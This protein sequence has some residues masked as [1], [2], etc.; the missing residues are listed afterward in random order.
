MRIAVLTSSRADYGIY[1][2]LL[3]GLSNDSFFQLRIIAFGTH[4]SPFH[5]YT[6]NQINNDGFN[7]YEKLETLILGDTEEAISNAIG[8]TITKFSSL[9]KKLKGEVELVFALGDR[10][11]MFAAVAASIPFNIKIAHLHGGETTSGAIDDKFRHSISLMSNI[12]FTSTSMYADKV[13]EIVG[14]KNKIFHVGSLSLDN[15]F[16]LKLLTKK[17]VQNNFNIDLSAPTILC[18]IHPETVSTDLN[19]SFANI[20]AEVFELVSDRYQVLITMPN[21]DTMGNV[22]RQRFQKLRDANSQ[23]ICVENLGTLGYFSCMK[24]SSFLLGNTSSGI[25]EAP[26]LQK[27]VIN[28]GNRQAGRARSQNIFDVDFNV[29]NILSTINKVE[30]LGDYKGGNIYRNEASVTSMIIDILKRQ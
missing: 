29:T 2:P 6:I 19:H 15:L 12:H 14:T 16:N 25:I 26:S 30:G 24:H 8:N 13:S 22:I 27:Y 3:K 21:A 28:I 23:I 20:I 18:T 9:W 4:L 10:Y 5:G 1:L 11:E 17:Q 7:V